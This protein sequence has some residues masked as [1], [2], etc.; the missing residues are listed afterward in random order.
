MNRLI[1]VSCLAL[2][3]ITTSTFSAEWYITGVGPNSF[4]YVDKSSIK[5]KG[6]IKQYW[7]MQIYANATS[8]GYDSLKLHRLVDCQEMTTAEDYV[9]SYSNESVLEQGS[10]PVQWKPIPPDSGVERN[11]KAICYGKLV[12]APIKDLDVRSEQQKIR[13]FNSRFK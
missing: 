3:F 6:S 2:I 12:G 7:A 4:G 8:G 13:E 9:L 11:A 5:T 10:V 1:K